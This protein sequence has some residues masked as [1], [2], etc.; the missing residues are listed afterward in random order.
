MDDLATFLSDLY[1]QLKTVH[2]AWA[3]AVG[4]LLFVLR[5]KGYLKVPSVTGKSDP[6]KSRLVD[7]V[8][9]KYD[10]R[11]AAG[12]EDDDVYRDL[13]DRIRFDVDEV[14]D[15]PDAPDAPA[16]EGLLDWFRRD[17]TAG[18]GALSEVARAR[19]VEVLKDR[20]DMSADEAQRL[21]DRVKD[22]QIVQIGLET[23]ALGDGKILGRLRDLIDWLGSDEGQAKI[24]RIVQRLLK[25]VLLLAPLFAEKVKSKA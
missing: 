2:P 10:E 21:I 22:K 1:C 23:G 25:L 20:Y 6:L 8:G 14:H 3:A 18:E 5:S 16:A 4:V 13:L 12:E 15:A 19:A 17:R 24:E 7:K 11:V 9:A